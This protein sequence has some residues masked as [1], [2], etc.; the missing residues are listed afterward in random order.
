MWLGPFGSRTSIDLMRLHSRLGRL[1]SW[2]LPSNA[3]QVEYYLV[4]CLLSA[5]KHSNGESYRFPSWGYLTQDH[6]KVS[7]Y[8]KYT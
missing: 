4:L 8:G 7:C 6:T 5:F 2:K 1:R 3:K